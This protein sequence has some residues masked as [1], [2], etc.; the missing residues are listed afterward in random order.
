MNSAQSDRE[1]ESLKSGLA[2]LAG[3]RFELPPQTKSGF[4]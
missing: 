3:L 1:A 2:L 4:M